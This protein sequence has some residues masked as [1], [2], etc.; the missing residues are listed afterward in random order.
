MIDAETIRAMQI[1]DQMGVAYEGQKSGLLNALI[2]LFGPDEAH[3]LNLG[4][5]AKKFKPQFSSLMDKKPRMEVDDSWSGVRPLSWAD[6]AMYPVDNEGGAL[7]HEVFK[8]PELYR[9]YPELASARVRFGEKGAGSSWDGKTITLDGSFE[10]SRY[11]N[12]KLKETIL[13]EIQHAIQE[14][15]GFARGGSPESFH[16]V[17]IRDVPEWMDLDRQAVNLMRGGLTPEK[18]ESLR[19]INEAKKEV[20]KKYQH[21]QYK[22]LAGEIESRD[23][24]DRAGL[25]AEERLRKAHYSQQGIPLDDVIVRYRDM[26]AKQALQEPWL[27]LVSMATSG[28]GVSGI[29]GKTGAALLDAF[30]GYLMNIEQGSEKGADVLIGRYK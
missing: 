6:K 12:P 17:D 13:H 29:M 21:N 15:E 24:A 9:N 23:V 19:E 5:L 7:L 25:T 4:P 10:H 1:A 20:L 2:N 14:K 16:S 22:R 27:D 26:A 8:H 18:A 30:M 11:Y 28:V 3:A